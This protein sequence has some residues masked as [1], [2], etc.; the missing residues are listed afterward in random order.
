MG[1]ENIMD[2][3]TSVAPLT[4]ADISSAHSDKSATYAYGQHLIEVSKFYKTAFNYLACQSQALGAGH[5][6]EFG[7][8]GVW[9]FRHALSEARKYHE[10]TFS[11]MYFHAF[12]SFE[13]FPKFEV[14]D[15]SYKFFGDSHTG[16]L[17]T[18]EEE[19]WQIVQAHGIFCDRIFTH[20]GFYRDVL[21]AEFSQL[22]QQH[23]I[24]ASFINIDCDFYESAVPV[25]EFITDFLLDGTLIYLDDYYAIPNGLMT[26]GIPRAF[27]EFQAKNK[28]WKFYPYREVGIYGKSFIAY[29]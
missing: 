28:I 7:C 23:G 3:Y 17:A 5:Y 26:E 11:K 25:F 13:G 2:W 29:R 16:L 24:K 12:D 8:H 14:S 19:F 20:K 22:L 15:P 21:T 6:M 9:S 27:H 4:N 10:N 1:L 18:S